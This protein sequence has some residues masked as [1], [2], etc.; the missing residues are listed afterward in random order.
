MSTVQVLDESGLGCDVQALADLANYVLAQ[1]CLHPDC[2]LA[3]TCVDAAQMAELNDRWMGEAG[4]TDVL[5]FPMDE[6]RPA[7]P[8]EEPEPGVLGDV[9]LCPEYAWDQGTGRTPAAALEFLVVH[10][11]LHLVGYD[12]AT[13]EEYG[14]MFAVQDELLAGWQQVRG[15]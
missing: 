12:H 10:G 13:V 9:V 5:S 4:P 6:L 1:M 11:I 14:E 15:G 7:A 2:E 8:G 3:I